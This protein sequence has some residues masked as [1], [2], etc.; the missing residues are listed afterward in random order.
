MK[1]SLAPVVDDLLAVVVQEDESGFQHIAILAVA[2]RRRLRV[3]PL[4]LFVDIKR[5]L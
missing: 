3:A 2:D 4:D 5:W 1:L